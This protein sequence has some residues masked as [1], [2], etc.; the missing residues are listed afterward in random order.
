MSKPTQMQTDSIFIEGLKVNTIIGV[1]PWEK[2][3]AQPLLF[4][5]E[6]FTTIISAAQ[7]DQLA[8]T[9]D[10]AQVSQDIIKMAQKESFELIETL[11]E[12]VCE[13]VLKHYRGVQAIQ[14][15][16]A[17]PHAVA[18]A[19]QVGVKIWRQRQA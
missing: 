16:L 19:K 12:Q 17:K 13:H 15:K 6:L 2:C 5:I 14:L 10:Y 8:D 18:E 3:Q 1:H 4:D 7:T 11:A 9:V